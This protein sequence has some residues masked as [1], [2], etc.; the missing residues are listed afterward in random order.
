MGTKSL[1]YGA[2][3]FVLHPLFVGLGWW[4]LYGAPLDPRL[5]IAFFVHDLGYLGKPNMD[6]PEGES[7]PELGAWIMEKLFGKKWGDFCRYH[8]RS[9]ARNDSRE[10]SLLCDADKYATVLVPRWLYL[11]L[12]KATGEIDE[13]LAHFRQSLEHRGKYAKNWDIQEDQHP[14]D[15]VAYGSVDHLYW[16]MTRPFTSDRLKDKRRELLFRDSGT[17]WSFRVQPIPKQ[18]PPQN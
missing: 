14:P 3:Q 9:A 7:H 4:K 6:G 15:G 13:Y 2:H 1:L 10:P 18:H 16:A 8:S 5:L 17:F 12:V 11:L